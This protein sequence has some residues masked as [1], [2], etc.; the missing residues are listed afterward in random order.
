MKPALFFIRL[1]AVIA[2]AIIALRVLIVMI[3]R[4]P[5]VVVALS[6]I[7]FLLFSVA[8]KRGGIHAIGLRSSKISAVSAIASIILFIVSVMIL[9]NVE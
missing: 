1:I 8:Y 9:L 4:Q 7:A 5:G 6:V 3:T 2:A